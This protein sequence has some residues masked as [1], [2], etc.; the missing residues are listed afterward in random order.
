MAVLKARIAK[1]EAEKRQAKEL[2]ARRPQDASLPVPLLS[3]RSPVPIS[4]A[5]DRRRIEKVYQTL[6]TLAGVNVVFDPDMQN[7]DKTITS[8]ISGVTFQ[9]A[10]DQVGLINKKA[11]RVL[12]QNTILIFDDT[13]AQTRQRWDDQVMRT[14]YL[15]NVEAKDL[16]A[17][18]RT[19]PR[20]ADQGIEERRH[21]LHHRDLHPRRDGARRPFH[22]L[23]RQ[24]E[25]RDPGGGRDPRNQS[26]QGQGVRPPALELP[27]G[28]RT[29]AD[30]R[31]KERC[32]EDSRTCAPSS[33]RP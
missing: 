26:D 32:Q 7:K 12:D 5:D 3:P 24:A 14:F 30:G 16:E 15:E 2:S 8:N 25:G 19:R 27:G 4:S 10:L 21:Q 18:L 6:G 11:Y 31:A 1:L 28:G 23:E 22:P 9:E 20:R 17:P 29:A 13:N 33:F